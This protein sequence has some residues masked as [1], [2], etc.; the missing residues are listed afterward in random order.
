[1]QE[2]KVLILGSCVSRDPFGIYPNLNSE[3]HVVDY[4]ART[5]LA[6]LS[7]TG[8]S[9]VCDLSKISSPFQRKMVQRDLSKEFFRDISTLSFDVLL[10]DFVDDR[11]GFLE[12]FDGSGITNSDE[13]RSAQLIFSVDDHVLIPEFSDLF[14]EKWSAGWGKLWA[15]LQET[16]QV[17][18]VLINKVYWAFRDDKDVDFPNRDRMN[19]ANKYLDRL[20]GALESFLPEDQ[21]INY[22]GIPFVGSTSHVWGRSTFH[23]TK[24]VEVRCLSEVNRLFF[25]KS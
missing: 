4:Y 18:K 22:Q 19:I 25:A 23:Y 3:Y 20:Y 12:F 5:S 10:I 24:D 1:M 21:F 6:S 11:F 9:A 17:R 16:S 14:Y 2:I 7:A 8:Y 15:F 13:F